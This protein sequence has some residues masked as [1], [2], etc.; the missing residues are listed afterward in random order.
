MAKPNL[1][2]LDEPT[3]HLDIEMREALAEALQDFDGTLVVVAHDRHLLKATTD[4][5]GWWPTANLKEFEGDLDDYKQ[6]AREYAASRDRKANPRQG[7]PPNPKMPQTPRQYWSLAI[8]TA[9]ARRSR[10]APKSYAARKPLADNS[11][12]S[13]PK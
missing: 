7:A 13:N 8:E 4:T 6:W 2:L 3:N 1:L 9:K 5:F 10:I 11:P 12:K